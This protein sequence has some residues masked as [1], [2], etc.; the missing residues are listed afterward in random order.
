MPRLLVR[1]WSLM[2]S[3]GA[4]FLLS[5]LLVGLLPGPAV[6]DPL[7]VV[8]GQR[9]KMVTL[10][11]GSNGS[12]GG[13]LKLVA[14][15]ETD[16]SALVVAHY[17]PSGDG[18]T[19]TPDAFV[20]SAPK[21]PVAAPHALV[22]L[23]FVASLPT[24][25]SPADLD[26]I[27]QL[28]LKGATP[29]APLDITI[30]GKAPA[31]SGVAIVPASLSIHSTNWL[32]PFSHANETRTGIQLRGPGVPLLFRQSSTLSTIVLL[33]ASDGHEIKAK[34]L[35]SSPAQGG[36][37]AD[38]DVVVSGGLAPGNYAGSLPLSDL[39]TGAPSLSIDVKSADSAIWAILAVGLGALA[40]GGIYLASNRKRRKD[41]LEAYLAGGL[42]EYQEKRDQLQKAAA[43]GPIP[44]WDLTGLGKEDEWFKHTWRALPETR[45]VQ[46]VSSEISWSRSEADLDVAEE[47]V[48]AILTRIGRWLQ[49]ADTYDLATLQQVAKLNPLSLGGVWTRTRTVE[50]TGSLLRELREIEPDSDDATRALVHRV[51]DQARWHAALATSWQM[52]SA[53]LQQIAI[54]PGDYGEPVVAAV[55]AVD[56]AKADSESTLA[57][58][59]AQKQL[60]LETTLDRWNKELFAIYKGPEMVLSGPEPAVILGALTAD[61]ARPADELNVSLLPVVAQPAAPADAEP[62]GATPKWIEAITVTDI[63]WSFVIVVIA[64]AAYLPHFYNASW[65]TLGDYA[66]AFIAGFLGNLAINWALL[67]IFTS[68]SIRARKPPGGNTPGAI[69]AIVGAAAGH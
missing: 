30:E 63:I 28:E 1:V 8:N 61:A 41:L 60:E 38:G 51:A 16:S 67:P 43:P 10:A 62:V 14:R 39:A 57:T 3:R 34:L 26:G 9:T 12:L 5:C 21:A 27:L 31:S 65:G 17:Y 33:R 45:G 44:L 15:N 22:D 23:T 42:K 50:D 32:G 25:S 29:P 2:A 4:L 24:K 68:I 52:K 35:A 53:V 66:T 37:L 56:L 59:T 64:C 6:G 19:T 7:T 13:S 49:V 18:S 69:G 36:L 58:R 55:E 11:E 47:G 46:G 54:N 40:G 20:L 48:K